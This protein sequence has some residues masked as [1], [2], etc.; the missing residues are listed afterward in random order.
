MFHNQGGFLVANTLSI[1]SGKNPF[2]VDSFRGGGISY[3]LD[4]VDYIK[5]GKLREDYKSLPL[6]Y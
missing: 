5:F 2:V 1:A 6:I 3:R 4:N